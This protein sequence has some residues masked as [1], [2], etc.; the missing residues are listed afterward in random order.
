MIESIILYELKGILVRDMLRTTLL[1]RKKQNL[2]RVCFEER[3]Y[4]TE[5]LML[6]G[7]CA[8]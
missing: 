8:S 5:P 3:P 1:Q 2:V 7:K 6:I 4:L